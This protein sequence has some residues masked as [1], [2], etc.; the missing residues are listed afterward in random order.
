MRY[1]IVYDR[2]GRIRVRCGAGVFTAEQGW[3]IADMLRNGA[4]AYSVEVCPVNGSILIN[5]P[6]NNRQNVLSIL[7]G[8]KRCSLPVGK[9]QD[10]DVKKQID[11]DFIQQTVSLVAGHF[12]KKL[13]PLP[14]RTAVTFFRAVGFWKEG[15]ASLT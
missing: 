7:N 13:L 12:L 15:I 2:P 1:K 4:A 8:L 11:N 6:E 5:Y 10:D 9:P 14:V 3:G